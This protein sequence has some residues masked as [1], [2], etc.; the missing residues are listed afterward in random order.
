[1]RKFTLL[2]ATAL[3]LTLGACGG[4]T[5][6]GLESVHQPVVTRTD[7][8]YDMADA[9][10]PGASERLAAWFDSLNVHYGDRVSV[11]DPSASASNRT[12]VAAVAGRYGL[13]LQDAAPVTQGAIAP[14]AF[15]VVVSRSR[16]DVPGCPDWSRTSQGNYN[17]DAPSN[18]GCAMNSNLAA[19]AA[20]PEDL[21]AGRTP[22]RTT[23][24]VTSRNAIRKVK[25]AN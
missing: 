1:M 5:N 20:D 21:V 18:Y 22:G 23:D 11:D 25:G 12:A 8:V 10:G 3:L 6:R 17:N 9:Y 2:P 4:T 13:L 14:G 16:A 19:M 15:R 7:Y 24:N